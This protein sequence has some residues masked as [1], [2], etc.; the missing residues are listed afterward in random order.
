[1]VVTITEAI[2]K[3]S[4][5]VIIPEFTTFTPPLLLVVTVV[6]VKICL[7]SSCSVVSQ[8]FLVMKIRA[9]YHSFQ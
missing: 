5:G 4:D 8:S 7:S 9:L 6:L 2:F 3:L 1:M